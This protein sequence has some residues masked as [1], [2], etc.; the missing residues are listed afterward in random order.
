MRYI[1]GVR[2]KCAIWE[3][4]LTQELLYRVKNISESVEEITQSNKAILEASNKSN[5]ISE[6]LGWLGG[7]L[8]CVGLGLA[9]GNFN[10]GEMTFQYK[11]WVPVIFGVSLFVFGLV[12]VSVEKRSES[13]KKTV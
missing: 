5:R 10:Y 8:G 1:E 2:Q 3:N 13:R 12:K 9:L 11:L 4:E 7:A 6:L